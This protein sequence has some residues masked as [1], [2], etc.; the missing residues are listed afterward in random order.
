M[1]YSNMKKVIEKGNKEF[2]SGLM[3]QEEY[4]NFKTTNMN[5]LDVFLMRDRITSEQYEE[6]SGMFIPSNE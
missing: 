4:E 5:K 1:V 3:T 2:E 6:L